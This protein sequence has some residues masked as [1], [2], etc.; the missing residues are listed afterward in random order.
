MK[1]TAVIFNWIALV[2]TLLGA[3]Y[4]FGDNTVDPWAMLFLVVLIVAQGTAL[5]TMK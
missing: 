5:S 4:M 3:F 1:K 2:W